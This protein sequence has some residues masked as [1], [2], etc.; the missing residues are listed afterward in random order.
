MVGK[1]Y[2]LFSEAIKTRV[3][4]LLAVFVGI[5]LVVLLMLGLMQSNEAGAEGPT[6][7][8]GGIFADTAWIASQSPYIVTGTVTLFPG[9]TLTIKPG[10]EVRFDP[11]TSLTIR[12]TLI[13][14]GT[15]SNQIVFT[16]N[17]TVPEKDIWGGI[18]VDSGQGGN[19]SIRF[20]NISYAETGLEVRCCDFV[21]PG[22]IADSVFI[23]NHR[24]LSLMG[25]GIEVQVNRCT[26]ENNSI[27]VEGESQ[28]DTRVSNSVFKNN[29][30][31][32]VTGNGTSIFASTFISNGKA[33]IGAGL[34]EVRNSMIIANDVGVEHAEIGGFDLYNNTIISNTIGVELPFSAF[35][36]V[37]DAKFNNIYGNTEYNMKNNSSLSIEATSNWWG[38]T[39]TSAIDASIFDGR[40]D[41]NLGLVIYEPFLLGESV[42]NDPPVADNQVVTTVVNIPVTITLT[43]SDVNL[44]PLTYTI[45]TSPSHGSLGGVAPRLIYTPSANYIGTDSFTFTATD[46]RN[47]LSNVAKVKISIFDNRSPV[48]LPIILRPRG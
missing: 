33:L 38:T 22:N 36:V 24:G 25:Y 39:D 41:A 43:A 4:V 6:Y 21:G 18:E 13:A 12:G 7:V 32:F 44:D 46:N 47:A 17:A 3:F 9:Y 30:I 23:N 19:F 26:F 2:Q 8:S 27:G 29:D 40:D 45:V 37:P 48:Y 34:G 5:A 10:V 42:P 14:E 31:G 16:S 28:M 1:K 15:Q 20:A 35:A 11:G